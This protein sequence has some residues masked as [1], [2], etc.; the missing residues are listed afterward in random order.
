MI[1]NNV[2]IDQTDINVIDLFIENELVLCL[3]KDI[4]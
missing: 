2:I 3:I 4:L 1:L